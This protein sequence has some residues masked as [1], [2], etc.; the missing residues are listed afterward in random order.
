MCPHAPQ[1]A[2]VSIG[3]L[4]PSSGFPL[5]FANPGLH[6]WIAQAPLSHAA[7]A[8]ART[9]L[10][11]HD[12][13]LLTLLLV[14]VLQFRPSPGQLA[15]PGSHPPTWHM[16][17]THAAIPLATTQA[18]PHMPQLAALLVVF[19]SHPSAAIMSQSA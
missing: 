3:V 2:I 4:H 6:A 9:H 18:F 17:P 5:Q 15:K 11:L 19:T 16:P 7:V 8:F 14:L 12:P 13:Q 1:L 10:L